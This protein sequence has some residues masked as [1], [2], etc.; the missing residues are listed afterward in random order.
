MDLKK[1]YII[2]EI[3]RDKYKCDFRREFRPYFLK[4]FPDNTPNWDIKYKLKSLS[5][6]DKNDFLKPLEELWN[7]YDNIK[8]F[9]SLKKKVHTIK[10]YLKGDVLVT[11]DLDVDRDFIILNYLKHWENLKYMIS[12]NQSIKYKKFDNVNILTVRK[13]KVNRKEAMCLLFWA[14][15]HSIKYKEYEEIVRKIKSLGWEKEESRQ[16][17][18][19]YYDSAN[20]LDYQDENVFHGTDY[21]SS[22]SFAGMVYNPTNFLYFNE[23]RL[24]RFMDMKNGSGKILLLGTRNYLVDE[25]ESMDINRFLYFSSIIFYLYGFRNPNDI[26]LTVYYDPPPEPYLKTFF[27][28]YKTDGNKLLGVGDVSIRGYGTWTKGGVK[29]HLDEWFLKEWP[30]LFHAEDYGDMIFNPRFYI[31]ILGIKVITMSADLVRRMIRHRAA[32]YADLIAYNHFMPNP[33]YIEEPP[34]KYIVSHKEET[35][36]TPEKLRDLMR[37]IKNYL[38][39]R[40]DLKYT[41][42]EIANELNLSKNRIEYKNEIHEKEYIPLSVRSK[43]SIIR[44][45]IKS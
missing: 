9:K 18:I 41:I 5:S 13:L 38:K 24:D 35:Y 32:S 40:Y 27:E 43:V 44:E 23:M 39:M 20:I 19:I 33:V 10:N 2:D 42:D 25:I 1:K 15:I 36:N 31:N 30:R 14:N 8:Y 6:I 37:K 17:T 3:C 28:Y 4:Y 11:T 26:D 45:M 22:I 34:K 7:Y 21:D 29:E 16:I 12:F